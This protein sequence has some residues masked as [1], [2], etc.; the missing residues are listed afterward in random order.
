M[1][2]RSLAAFLF[3]LAVALFLLPGEGLAAPKVIVTDLKG[4]VG[5]AMEA[6]LDEVF[7][8]AQAEGADLLIL[9]LDT[10]GGLVSST[11]EMTTKILNSA[12]PV[13]VW[14]APSGA[15][16]ASA[17]AFIVQSSAV[18]VM[19][20][21]TH[22]GA[23]HPVGAGGDIGEE[24]MKKKVASDL[25]A[26]MRSLASERGRNA[27]RAEKMVTDSLSLT[28][29]EALKEGVI[30]LV[31]D[32]LEQILSALEGREV[33][34]GN[35]TV[36]LALEGA[37]VEEMAPSRRLQILAFLTRP[38]VA[39][40]LLMVGLYAIVFEVL[41]PGGFVMGTSGAV[42]VL[43]GAYGLRMLPFNWAGI[44]LLVAGVAVMIL[45]LIVGGMG[46]LSL[47]GVAALVLGGLVTFRG[48]P[49]GE[50]LRVSMGVLGGAI[51]ALSFLFVLAAFAV[52]RSLARKAVS[53]Q[54]GLIGA[55]GEVKS[56]LTPEG[57][58][59]CRGELW[60]ARSADGRRLPVGTAIRVV[61]VDGLRLIV[62]A[63]D[64]NN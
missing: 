44:V 41:T 45:D 60:R 49:G 1:K 12:I 50:L 35:R 18:A 3:A 29:S 19:A 53:G 22:I 30:D 10:P 4:V 15:R 55:V 20:S 23:A 56:D 24:D 9:R 33:K 2:G 54:E 26:Q 6:H 58:V 16:A 7:D 37:S 52:W 40:L 57:M 21:G 8:A 46:I 28:S 38:D 61:K 51:A 13:V 11:R 47:F 25:A 62:Q 42:M 17:G 5:T 32:D 27:E 64:E 59:L 31:A 14:V 34:R 48:A 36:R 39:Y 43:M 63:R